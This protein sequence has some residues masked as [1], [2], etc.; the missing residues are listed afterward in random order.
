MSKMKKTF[1]KYGGANES[2]CIKINKLWNPNTKRCVGDNKL[3]RKKGA[4]TPVDIEVRN[5]TVIPVTVAPP[6]EA[7]LVTPVTISKGDKVEWKDKKGKILTGIIKDITKNNYKV[8]CQK[9]KKSNWHV[10]LDWPS[11]KKKIH[12]VVIVQFQWH[13]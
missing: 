9:N 7:V 11:L 5:E 8:C 13:Q 4:R 3:N 1:N 6:V 12:L 2:Q 10:P